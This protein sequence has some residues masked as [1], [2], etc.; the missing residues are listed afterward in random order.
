MIKFNKLFVT[1]G[2]AGM[3]AVLGSA[4]AIV[5][6]EGFNG[7]IPPPGWT[8][9]NNSSPVGVTNW[10]QGD[11]GVFTAQA[12]AANSYIAANFLA[13]GFGGN[14]RDW[15]LTPTVLLSNGSVFSFFTR[16]ETG[17]TF[18][19]QLEVLLCRNGPCTNTADFSTVLIPT[20]TVPDAWTRESF[21]FS[22][23]GAGDT[24]RIGFLYLVN[25]TSVN[26][27]YI[28]IDTVQV[29][30][31]STLAVFA[32][33]LVMLGWHLRRATCAMMMVARFA[34][35]AVQDGLIDHVLP[36]GGYAKCRMNG[37]PMTGVVVPC[38]ASRP[39]WPC[40][41]RVSPVRSTSRR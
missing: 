35:N 18:G 32:V 29:P 23:L 40:S 41:G 3:L 7:A 31:P 10:F 2:I 8:I 28:G 4:Q 11:T 34:G 21:T 39:F 20:F 33:A 15:L 38:C 12:G 30:E 5:L 9:V 26:G 25:D 19:D 1:I 17:S 14:I 36:F 27:D 16:T 22:G 6:D 13:A 24:G 37:N